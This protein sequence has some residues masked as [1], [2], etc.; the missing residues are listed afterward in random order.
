MNYRL[1]EL[2]D[3]ATLQ[4]LLDSLDEINRLLH[5]EDA[6]RLWSAVEA[7]M[8]P[9]DPKPYA[10]EYRITRPDGAVRWLEARGIAEFE[11]TQAERTLVSFVGTVADVTERRLAEEV[12]RQNEA[13]FRL[14]ADA[15]PAMLW[16]TDPEGHCTFLSRQWY[17]Y[18]GQTEAEYK[19]ELRPEVARRLRNSLVLQEIAKRENIELGQII[20][21]EAAISRLA[22]SPTCASSTRRDTGRWS[23]PRSAARARTRPSSAAC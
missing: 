5:P 10:V 9:D 4:D 8:Q 6:P 7:S 18:T 13:R 14:M 23:R 2:L 17:E 15:S 19:E 20:R 11:A 1:N 21:I 12:L 16:L 3:I 22:R